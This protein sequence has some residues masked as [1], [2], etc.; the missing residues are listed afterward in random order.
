[1]EITKSLI[2][3]T[4]WEKFYANRV[5]TELHLVPMQLVNILKTSLGKLE[6]QFK[7]DQVKSKKIR[8]KFDK[9]SEQDLEDKALSKGAYEPW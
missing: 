3:D 1:M 9:Y 5:V 2:G 6:D 4:I 8:T 7:A